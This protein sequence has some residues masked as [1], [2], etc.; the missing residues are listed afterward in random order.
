MFLS[1][2]DLIVNMAAKPPNPFGWSKHEEKEPLVYKPKQNDNT[3]KD[4]TSKDNTIIDLS[5]SE[6]EYYQ[7]GSHR[8]DNLRI[9]RKKVDEVKDGILDNIDKALTRDDKVND[10]VTKA[11]HLGTSSTNFRRTTTK[12]RKQIYC[13]YL[14]KKWLCITIILIILTII[15]IIMA[16][17]IKK[18]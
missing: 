15:I 7:T 9:V 12:L 6:D 16:S 8:T 11:D 17:V 2:K 13:D 4:N 5:S 1:N 18:K 14:K 3:S 10:L